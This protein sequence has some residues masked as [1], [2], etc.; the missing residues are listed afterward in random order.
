MMNNLVYFCEGFL[1]I[2]LLV[3][4]ECM[5]YTTD[6]QINLDQK[7]EQTYQVIF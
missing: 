4:K 3:K 5:E 6:E 2:N 1:R 7:D